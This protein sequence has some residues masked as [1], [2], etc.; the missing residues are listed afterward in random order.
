MNIPKIM[1]SLE[2]LLG[3]HLG[4]HN[5]LPVLNLP[6]ER[7]EHLAPDCLRMKAKNYSK[8]SRHCGSGG[9][10][11]EELSNR[12]EGWIH[13]CPWGVQKIDIPLRDQKGQLDGYLFGVC[14]IRRTFSEEELEQRRNAMLP[15]KSLIESE[16]HRENQLESH[17]E[18]RTAKTLRFIEN[19]LE[20]PVSAEDLAKY[21][22]I[23][24]SRTRN[25]LKKVVG[26]SFSRLLLKHRL[27]YAE[28]LLIRTRISIT[29]ISEKLHFYDSS[30]F[31]RSF[32]EAKGIPPL[33]F[34]QSYQ[35]R[36]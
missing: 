17:E 21:L 29:E 16:L 8:C 2:D 33:K 15:L 27:Q 31:S 7:R 9:K 6:R 14:D 35:Q 5:S 30:Q 13:R 22:N 26:L 12:P 1:A 23:S 24:S 25:W 3:I 34:R 36:V 19:N 20:N 11:D 4:Y 18:T 10:V 32:K 28:Q